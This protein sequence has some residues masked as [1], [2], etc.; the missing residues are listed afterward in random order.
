MRNSCQVTDK[1]ESNTV[2][3]AEEKPENK[4]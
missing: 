3:I 1:E 4:S 2:T